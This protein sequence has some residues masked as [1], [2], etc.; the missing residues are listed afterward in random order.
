LL[1][2]AG[3]DALIPP[4][5][6]DHREPRDWRIW[7]DKPG[8]FLP[9]CNCCGGGATQA[10]FAMAGIKNGSPSVRQTNNYKWDGASWTSKAAVPSARDSMGASTPANPG[11]AYIYGGISNSAF[12]TDCQGYT[13]D[14]WTTETGMANAVW[15]AQGVA[16]GGYC[17]SVGGWNSSNVPQT[18]NYQ[19][20]PGGNSWATKTTVTVARANSAGGYISS[21]FYNVCGDNNTGSQTAQNYEYDPSGNSWTTRT[22]FP[23]ANDAQNG[24]SLSG[25]LYINLGSPAGKIQKTYIV[26]TWSAGTNP[27]A[28]ASN[29][30][31]SGYADDGAA[32]VGYFTGGYIS[33]TSSSTQHFDFVPTT[34]TSLTALPTNTNNLGAC[35][36]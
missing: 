31:A 3:I 15:R 29:A 10:Y 11:S 21:K 26:D 36:A 14:T 22:A 13:P 6:R 35:L 5:L 32:Q 30:Y 1:R 27:S 9:N 2:H 25:T 12:L 16:V 4:L 7:R 17:Y 34:W 23:S 33:P 19:Y 18:Y 24:W 28:A 20:N 8:F